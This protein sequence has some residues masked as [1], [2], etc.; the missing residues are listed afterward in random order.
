MWPETA[1]TQPLPARKDTSLAG[2]LAATALN[3]AL[4]LSPVNNCP[5]IELA[6]FETPDGKSCG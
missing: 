5:V 3:P 4:A 1:W 2:K 6:L